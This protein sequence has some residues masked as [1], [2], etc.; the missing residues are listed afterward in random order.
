M[1][2]DE[3]VFHDVTIFTDEPLERRRSRFP[4][5]DQTRPAYDP[6]WAY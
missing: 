6:I 4:H 2:Y 5:P 3:S 1:Y